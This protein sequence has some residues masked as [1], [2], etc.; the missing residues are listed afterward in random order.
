MRKHYP[1]TGAESDDI[2]IPAFGAAQYIAEALRRAG[3]N[4]TRERLRHVLEQEMAGFS[5]GY[6]PPCV[7][8]R[9]GDHRGPDA[10]TLSKAVNGVW[11]TPDA[12]YRAS[13]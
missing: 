3:P 10:V 13:F 4:L 7:T 1:N 9:P 8:A 5:T 6:G 2:G 11:T 12:N